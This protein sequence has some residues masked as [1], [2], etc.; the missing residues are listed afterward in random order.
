MRRF[1]DATT[2][3]LIG[4]MVGTLPRIW[5]YIKETDFV[6]KKGKL[7]ATKFKCLAPEW[8]ISLLWVILVAAAGLMLV[9]VIEKIAAN[10]EEK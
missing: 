8:N 6:L 7:V 3:A 1:K 4:F 5:P 9:L 10:G 2:A